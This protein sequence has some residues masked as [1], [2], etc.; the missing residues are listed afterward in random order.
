MPNISGKSTVTFPVASD[1]TLLDS[2]AQ[3]ILNV[4]ETPINCAGAYA[5]TGNWFCD[6]ARKTSFIFVIGAADVSD[7]LNNGVDI[8]FW[9]Q[10]GNDAMFRVI[11]F[12][13][14]FSHANS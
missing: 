3:P 11:A 14:G 6:R 9:G 4:R 1:M 10:C 2:I 7:Q 13:Y 12:V 5:S 8:Y